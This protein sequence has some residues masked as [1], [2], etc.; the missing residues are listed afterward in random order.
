[1]AG[2]VDVEAPPA[3]HFRDVY[4]VSDLMET[5]LG[6]VISS[7]QA[8]SCAHVQYFMYQVR[9]SVCVFVIMF[10]DV[11]GVLVRVLCLCGSAC[12]RAGC[13]KIA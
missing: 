7:R 12:V 8:L 2:L 9:S 10:D 6:R 1:M 11:I 4:I 5:D 3:E 13:S